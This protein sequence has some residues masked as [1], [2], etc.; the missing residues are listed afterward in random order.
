MKDN[1]LVVLPEINYA[2]TV[3]SAKAQVV[4]YGDVPEFDPSMGKTDETN[5]L[6]IKTSKAINKESSSVEKLRKQFKEPSLTYG[7]S[8]DSLA[9][10]IQA[11]F[12]PAKLKFSQARK[13]IDSYEQEQEQK[14]IDDE[15]ERVRLIDESINAL[16]MIPSDCIGMN[17]IG[18]TETYEA[19]EIPDP[20]IYAEK[21]DH[22]NDVYKDT[23]TKLETM[24]EQAFK[25]EEAERIQAENQKRLDEESARLKAE[26]DAEREEFEKEK[27][28][29]QKEKDEAQRIKN[30]ADEAEALKKANEEAEALAIQQDQEAQEQ[31]MKTQKQLEN[32]RKETLG[33]MGRAY[34]R[35]GLEG[36]LT[37]IENNEVRGVTYER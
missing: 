7:R 23:I 10:E 26:Q 25:N 3:E 4:K 15:M 31:A 14:R 29:F 33:E 6:I 20:L 34:D 8:V 30:E 19:I 36:I 9:K 13:Q 2:I 32:N 22:A 5:A 24:I 28:E 18:L 35:N 21:I 37:A 27:A 11:V 17:S 16:R 12:E 1:E